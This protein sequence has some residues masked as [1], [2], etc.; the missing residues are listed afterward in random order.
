MPAAIRPV[1]MPAAAAR[2]RNRKN[3]SGSKK[4]WVI[5]SSPLLIWPAS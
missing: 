4:N 5:F 1:S 2:S 3:V